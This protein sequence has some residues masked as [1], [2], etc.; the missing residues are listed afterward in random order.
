MVLG[1]GEGNIEITTDKQSYSPGETIKGKVK[2]FLNNQKSANGFRIKFYGEYKDRGGRRTRS[3]RLYEQ[4]IE[5][6]SQKEYSAGQRD[7]DFEIKLP[8]IEK[9]APATGMFAGVMNYLTNLNNP[10]A[11]AKWYLDASLELSGSFDINKKLR[12]NFVP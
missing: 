2:L 12:I 1:L 11:R 7:Y 6:D 5:L 10:V 4:K 9:P 8:K 3:R